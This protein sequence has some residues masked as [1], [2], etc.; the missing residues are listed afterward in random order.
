[1]YVKGFDMIRDKGFCLESCK[2]RKKPQKLENWVSKDK[3]E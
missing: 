3:V 2:E 1:M